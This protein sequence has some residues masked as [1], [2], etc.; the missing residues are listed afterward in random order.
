LSVGIHVKEVYPHLHYHGHG[1]LFTPGT[2][3]SPHLEDYTTDAPD[4]DLG[5]VATLSRVHDFR[6]HPKHGALHGSEDVLFIDVG[7]PFGN[8]KVRD[9]TDTSLLNQNI[10]SLEILACAKVSDVKE[11]G[12]TGRSL[13][14]R[15]PSNEGIPVPRGFVQ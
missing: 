9:L 3:S 14:A 2:F 13:Y 4:V 11:F 15:Y 6:R 7:R 5:V 10:I 12:T 1:L 8:A